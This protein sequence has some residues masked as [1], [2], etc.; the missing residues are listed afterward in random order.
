MLHEELVPGLS[1]APGFVGGYWVELGE[2]QGTSVVVFES[3][4]AARRV[5]DHAKP[6]ETDAFTVE[7]FDIGEVVAHA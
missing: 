6:P 4:D 3:E 5:A 2:N 7:R 1:Q